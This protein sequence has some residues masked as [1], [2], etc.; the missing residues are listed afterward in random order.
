[1][2]YF[3]MS[4]KKREKTKSEQRKKELMR[5][6]TRNKNILI[7]SALLLVI[8]IAAF[9]AVS[10]MNTAENKP[11]NFSPV[12]DANEISE[13]Q[14]S[15]PISS[16]SSEASFYNYEHDGTDIHYFAVEGDDDQVHVA[17]D[18]CDVCYHAKKGYRQ[19]QGDMQCIN[20]GLT[21][22][23]DDIGEKNTGGGCWPS[24]IPIT[25][26]EEYVLIEKTDLEQKTYMFE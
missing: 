9:Y 8:I 7:G 19:T 16:I 6:K 23:I 15:I 18:A 1:M 10:L 24:F 11:G 20:C 2:R 22:P 4:R 13:T 17:I 3:P 21:F 12:S 5:R 26:T 25:I 14:I